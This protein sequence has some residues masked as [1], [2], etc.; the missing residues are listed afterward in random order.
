METVPVRLCKPQN[1]HYDRN[2]DADFCFCS[3]VKD[4]DLLAS[5]LGPD[6]CILIS[7]DDKAVVKLGVIA[8]KQQTAMVMH[9]EYK[10]RP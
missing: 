7:P 6:E 4:L 5:L 3:I 2:P 9:L 10:I 1:D 8:A